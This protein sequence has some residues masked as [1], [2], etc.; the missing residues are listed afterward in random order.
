[1]IFAI[2]VLLGVIEAGQVYLS[3][4]M[5]GRQTSLAWS[6]V[7]TFPSWIIMAALTLPI[8]YLSRRFRLERATLARRLPLHI[9]FAAAYGLLHLGLTGLAGLGVREIMMPGKSAG[10]D[11]LLESFWY[12]LRFYFVLEFVAYFAILGAFH[13]LYYYREFRARE[14]AASRLEASLA[15]ARLG[16][17]RSQLNPHFLFNTLNTISS[18]A[19]AGES[20]A[21]TET[22]GR[23]SELLRYA[24]EVEPGQQVPLERELEFTDGYLDIQRARFADR[25]TVEREIAPDTLQALVPTMLLQPVVENAVVHGIAGRTGPGRVRILTHRFGDTLCLQ[26]DDTGPGFAPG[27]TECDR[28]AGGG[29]GLSNTRERLRQLYGDAFRLECGASEA[30][31]ASVRISLPFRT[32]DP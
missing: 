22:L 32:Q 25:L 14:L 10:L 13:A 7:Q 29:I 26:V 23:L 12:L 9:G 18:L 20:E 11:V 24:L 17:L 27:S 19:L 8:P 6:F 31:G 1:M 15:A 4:A 28:P 16:A 2:A 3:A 21:V 5:Q 30:G